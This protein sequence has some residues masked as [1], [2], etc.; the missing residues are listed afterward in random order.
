M[1]LM[2]FVIMG[3]VIN[4]VREVDFST[5]KATNLSWVTSRYFFINHSVKTVDVCFKFM[6]KYSAG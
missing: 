6:V 4:K 2:M 5:V 3:Q 1:H